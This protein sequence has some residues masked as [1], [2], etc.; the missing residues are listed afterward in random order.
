[1]QNAEPL[2]TEVIEQHTESDLLGELEECQLTLVN[3]L[4]LVDTQDGIII[5]QQDK[6][7]LLEESL[8]NYQHYVESLRASMQTK[9]GYISVVEARVKK[10]IYVLVG[11]AFTSLALI[12]LVYSGNH[13]FNHAYTKLSKEYMELKYQ[14]DATAN[15]YNDLNY[16][17]QRVKVDNDI[18]RKGNEE[19]LKHCTPC[20]MKKAVSNSLPKLMKV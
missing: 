10:L 4:K 13:K 7:K 18:L 5:K 11:V 8:V 12:L 9:E 1:M 3:A 20:Q 2:D 16:K 17:Y 19:L 6:I 15:L 14:Q